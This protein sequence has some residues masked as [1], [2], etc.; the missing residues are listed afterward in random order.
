[1]PFPWAW[2]KWSRRKCS[3]SGSRSRSTIRIWSWPKSSCPPRSIGGSEFSTAVRS[4]PANTSWPRIT[5]KS[6][7]RPPP[8]V[9]ATAAA[10]RSPWNWRPRRPSAL[11][12]AANLI[13][14]GLYG[15][16]V[17]QSLKRF[18][19]IEV[20]D[21]PN[22]DAGFED[23]ILGDEIYRRIMDVFLRRIEARKARG[24]SG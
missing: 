24:V 12:C 6:S 16:D 11:L 23:A 9:N 5:G 13:G 10:K 19:V 22:V 14:D 20:N 17:K 3:A 7:T 2:P 4:L 8:A 15:V 18:C 21:N 1:M